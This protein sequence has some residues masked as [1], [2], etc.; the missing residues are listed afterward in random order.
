ML[1]HTTHYMYGKHNLSVT[2]TIVSFVVAIPM[3]KETNTP[4]PLTTGPDTANTHE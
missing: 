3:E 2:Y 1:L 4:K